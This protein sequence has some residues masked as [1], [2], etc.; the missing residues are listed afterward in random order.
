MANVTEVC[1]HQLYCCALHSETW[2]LLA[3]SYLI[4]F[5]IKIYLR[6]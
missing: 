3:G 1:F 6:A 4:S 5:A 2:H